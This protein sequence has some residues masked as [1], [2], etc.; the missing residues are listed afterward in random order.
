MR[1]YAVYLDGDSVCP[2]DPDF[3]HRMLFGY[4][5]VPKDFSDN[6]GRS[7]THKQSE[8]EDGRYWWDGGCDAVSERTAKDR[9]GALLPA[10]AVVDDDG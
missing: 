8:G 4:T 3:V 7:R 5:C 9:P 2:N 6:T 10:R 1:K